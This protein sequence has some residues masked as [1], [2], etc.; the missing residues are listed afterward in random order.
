MSNLAVFLHEVLIPAAP[1][2]QMAMEQLMLL[3]AETFHSDPD[4]QQILMDGKEA[5]GISVFQLID[6]SVYIIDRDN[7]ETAMAQDIGVATGLLV[8]IYEK[9][10]GAGSLFTLKRLR[11]AALELREE[12]SENTDM[13]IIGKVIEVTEKLKEEIG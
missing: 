7:H 13:S 4:T 5:G 11:G 1:N 6:G 2:P 3:T 10:H 9:T 12:N 8:E